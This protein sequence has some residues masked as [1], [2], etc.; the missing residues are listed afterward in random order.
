M[1]L[2][3][4][5]IAVAAGTLYAAY[6]YKWREERW[7]AAIAL[8]GGDPRRRGPALIRRYGCAGC[9]TIPGVSGATGLVGPPLRNVARR[10]YIG[11]VITNTPDNLMQWIVNPQALDPKR[12]CRSPAS[13]KRKQSMSRP[14]FMLPNRTDPVPAVRLGRVSIPGTGRVHGALVKQARPGR[15][16]ST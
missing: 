9:H 8:T 2:S 11:G 14:I 6:E 15:R 1:P 16:S 4:A 12:P 3:I 10:V 13:P 5:L 7:T